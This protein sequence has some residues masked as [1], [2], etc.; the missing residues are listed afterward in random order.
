MEKR[1]GAAVILVENKEHIDAMNHLLSVYSDLIIA[2]QGLRDKGVSIITV[3][4]EGTSDQINSLTGK[5]GRL[6]G[7][8]VKSVLTTYK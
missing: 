5:L 4:L 6:E 8:Q 7:V 1:F 2:R 3:I